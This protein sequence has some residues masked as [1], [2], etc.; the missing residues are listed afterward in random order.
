MADDPRFETLRARLLARPRPDAW[1]GLVIRAF[2]AAEADGG[3]PHWLVAGWRA[4]E[5]GLVPRLPEFAAIASPDRERA[6]SELLVHLPPGASL[7]LATPERVDAALVAQMVLEV[8][9]NLQPW[10]RD[11]LRAFVEAQR[12]A[13]RA[14]IRARYTDREDGYERMRATLL[15]GAGGD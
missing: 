15:G 13:D 3:P 5:N 6:L 11:G 14:R 1:L 2:P 10:H 4:D 12:A 9:R 8:D 7:H